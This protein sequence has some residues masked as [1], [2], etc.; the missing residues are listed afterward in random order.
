MKKVLACLFIF[1]FLLSG[2]AC[3][4]ARQA[5]SAEI[6]ASKEPGCYIGIF[7]E[8]IPASMFGLK[9]FEK[10]LG[11]QFAIIMWYQDWSKPFPK[12]LCDKVIKRNSV[13][14]IV[15]EPWLWT[16]K[17]KIKLDNIIAGEWDEYI[18][19]WA[20]DIK[21]WGGPI[22]LRWGHEFNIDGYPWG[23]V[24]NGKDP[25][26]YVEAFRHVK[27]IFMNEGALN[28]KFVWCPMN[29]SWPKERWNE[30]DK[31]YPG[32]E[33]VDWI[34]I[35]GYNWGTTQ[36][37]SNWL[38]FNELFR[39]VSRDLWRKHPTKPI[40]IAEFASAA[41]GGDKAKWIQSITEDLKKMPYIKAIQ[42]FDEMK[43][44]DWRIDSSKKTFNAFKQT[45]KNPYY[46][47]T[48]SPEDEL[49]MPI[50]GIKRN[51]INAY[52]T[53]TPLSLDDDVS[54][55]I[56]NSPAE[57]NSLGQIQEGTL[58]WKGPSDISGKVYIKWDKE[59]LYFSA[60][61]NDNK[62]MINS[63]KKKYIWNGDAVE[64]VLGLDKNADPNRFNLTD[65]DLQIGFGTGDSSKNPA[66]IWNW[67]NNESPKDAQISVS[68]AAG[69]N[70]YVLKAIVPWK[71]LS[72]T[73]TPS[74]R[75]FIGF[76]I[77]LD[78]S[79]S[80]DR[81]KQMVW[82]GDFLFYKDPGVWGRLEFVR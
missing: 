23:I 64:I 74:E 35:D 10:E 28:A 65:S 48:Y 51:K 67:K 66:S 47:A 81:T 57:I 41:Q 39:D 44:T 54:G 42:W 33:Y 5:V 77:A 3:L 36:S 2:F 6:K 45:I 82:N 17:E 29:D 79:D 49:A 34:G 15:W 61:I 60:L 19:S 30:I 1:V 80:A 21:T 59:N 7:R 76:D 31:A 50:L 69:P 38:T 58:L 4:T 52:Y 24:N 20:Q 71:S 73:F 32:D 72:T 63:K 26:K 56:T 46:A 37:W 40:M 27:K 14:H 11:K 43:E 22:F 55:W 62:P 75:D 78:D 53:N 12:A 8:G 70:G 18:R 9:D 16:D 68:R 25:A 13:P